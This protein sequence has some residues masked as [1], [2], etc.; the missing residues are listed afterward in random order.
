M[1][2][3]LGRILTEIPVDIDAQGALSTCQE[4]LQTPY[5]YAGILLGEPLVLLGRALGRR[6][7]NLFAGPHT[8]FCSEA[9]VYL[10]QKHLL[11]GVLKERV[12]LLDPRATDPGQLLGVMR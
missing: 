7:P 9:V 11:P 10:L 2:G 8:M 4:W 1:R 3:R 12:V 5:A 6:W